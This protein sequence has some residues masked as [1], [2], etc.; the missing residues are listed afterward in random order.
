MIKK[1][2]NKSTVQET[3]TS[4]AVASKIRAIGNSKGVILANRIIEEAGFSPG[5]N[6]LISV[7]DG[8]IL[9]SE[10]KTPEKVNTDLSTWDEQFKEI[11][12][13]GIKP[14]ND[15]WEGLNN[16]FDQEEWA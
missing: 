9:I 11:K 1:K 8:V 13:R 16:R 7:E 5:S 6:L 10:D 15:A 2:K 12:K 4:Y 14:D 3:A